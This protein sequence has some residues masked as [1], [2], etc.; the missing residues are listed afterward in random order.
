MRARERARKHVREVRDVQ[1]GRL[2]Q[3]KYASDQE[4]GLIKIALA[5]TLVQAPP[6]ACD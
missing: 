5:R 3:G 4:S 1:V 6:V 2:G